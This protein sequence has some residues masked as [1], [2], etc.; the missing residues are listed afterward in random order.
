MYS[1][2]NMDSMIMVTAGR[3]VQVGNEKKR[4]IAI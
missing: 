4:G 1:A 3:C 2:L